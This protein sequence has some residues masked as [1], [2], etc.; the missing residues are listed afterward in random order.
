MRRV[1]CRSR[2][3]C[4]ASVWEFGGA[5]GDHAGAL[6]E[7]KPHRDDSSP[8]S[9]AMNHPASPGPELLRI[10]ES[11]IRRHGPGRVLGVVWRQ[12]WAER[13]LARRGIRFR[14]TDVEEV[15]R[16]Y[17]A[18]TSEEF[19]VINGRQDWAN[20][21][22]IPRSL[23]GRVLDK[24]LRVLDLGCG[25][26]GSTRVLAFYCPLGSRITAYE[27]A[28][29]LWDVARRRAYRHRSGKEITVDF[30]CQPITETLREPDGSP[31][32]EKSVDV[33]SA[34]GVVGHH[35]NA[36]TVQ[37]LIQEL[38]RV[39]RPGGLAMLDVGPTLRLEPLRKL[40]Y[41]AG[42]TFVARTRSWFLDPTG[43][44]VFRLQP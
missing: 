16:A 19:D 10:P 9:K 29:P 37:P 32:A 11:D 35:L 33:A 44:A 42:F 6:P 14:K 2:P 5:A 38:L 28:E 18:M 27:L 26:G 12:W 36:E 30:C 24:P 43:Q 39:L 31:V 1:L 13:N 4:Y 15:R 17:A 20:W 7:P 21:R 22:T 40:L 34:S 8:H 25:T 23:S 3:L 41:S